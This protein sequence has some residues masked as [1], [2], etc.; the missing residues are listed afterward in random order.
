MFKG[1]VSVE[2]GC[3]FV[4]FEEVSD[5]WSKGWDI[6]DLSEIRGF[7]GTMTVKVFGHHPFIHFILSILFTVFSL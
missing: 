3:Y 7:I 2:C 1:V 5:E 6:V 4:L